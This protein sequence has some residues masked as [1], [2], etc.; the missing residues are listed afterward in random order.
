MDGLVDELAE[1]ARAEMAVVE[2]H[3]GAV[4]A[5]NYMKTQLVES[6]RERVSRIERGELKVI[7][8][9]VYTEHEPSPLQEGE[10]GGILTVDPQVEAV[11]DLRACRSGARSATSTR[12]TAALDELRA[13]RPT[14]RTRTSCPPRSPRPQAG[15]TTG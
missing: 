14:P 10:D 3:G 11:G 15:A 13:P 6:H 12:S 1:G 4:E 5:V 2:E 8:Q 7:G 9:N